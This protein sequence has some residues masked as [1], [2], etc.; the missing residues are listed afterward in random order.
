MDSC[1]ITAS[2]LLLVMVNVSMGIA[3]KAFLKA[4]EDWATRREAP[5]SG[6]KSTGLVP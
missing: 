1:T 3:L 2:G 6:A 5:P 4:L